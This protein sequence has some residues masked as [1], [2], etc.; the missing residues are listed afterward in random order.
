MV[1]YDEMDI[2]WQQPVAVQQYIG[3]ARIAETTLLIVFMINGMYYQLETYFKYT[4][5]QHELNSII[6]KQITDSDAFEKALQNARNMAQVTLVM[7][8]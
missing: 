7:A 3:I 5:D 2:I 1:R 6:T 4:H 8:T